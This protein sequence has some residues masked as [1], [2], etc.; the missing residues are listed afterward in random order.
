M[1]FYFN[2]ILSQSELYYYFYTSEQ[3]EHNIKNNRHEVC[4]MLNINE[5]D[6]TFSV[7]EVIDFE[8]VDGIYPTVVQAISFGKVRYCNDIILCHDKRLNRTYKFKRINKDVVEVLNHTSVFVKGTK[9]YLHLQS[10]EK[11]NSYRAFYNPKDL[12]TSNY[13]KTGI[14]NGV[15]TI[16]KPPET[17]LI[18]YENNVAIDSVRYNHEDSTSFMLRDQFLQRYYKQ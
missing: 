7:G 2:N 8:T 15:F 10:D 6:N 3:I 1:I 9:L 5:D 12:I 17:T 16:T 18:Y 4:N 14:R 11:A 13:W